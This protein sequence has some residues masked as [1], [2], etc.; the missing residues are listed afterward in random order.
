MRSLPDELFGDRLAA[1][2]RQIDA[3]FGERLNG[4][5]AGRHAA[6]G[7]DAPPTEWRISLRSASSF[8]KSPSA[9]GLRH[10]LPVQTKRTCFMNIR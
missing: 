2:I 8:L 9:I 5:L 3:L 6:P 4:M 10:T 1:K 7:A